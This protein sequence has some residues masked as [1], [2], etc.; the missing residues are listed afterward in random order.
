MGLIVNRAPNGELNAGIREEI[1]NQ[2]LNLIG[3]VPHSE[4]VYELD[5]EGKPTSVNLPEGSPVR[6]ALIQAVEKMLHG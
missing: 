4:D 6:T 5:C 1:E 2:G 3:V